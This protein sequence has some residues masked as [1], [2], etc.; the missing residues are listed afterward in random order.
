MFYFDPLWLLFSLPALA[1]MLWAQAKT[2]GAY[3]KYSEL[4]NMVGMP[5]WQVARRILDANGLTDVQIEEVPGELTDHYDPTSRV[6]RLSAGVAR[7]P[8]I[9]AMGVAAH[10]TGHAIQ[11]KQLYAPLIA[12]SRLVGPAN[13]GSNIGVY[14][15]MIGLMIQS[16]G[17]VWV[18]V[19][20]FSFAA[21]FALVTLPVEFDASKRA[22]AQLQGL[23]L[24]S[25]E[26]YAGARAVLNAAAWTYVAGFLSALMQLLYF[27]FRAMGMSNRERD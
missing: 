14:A 3:A 20:L 24:V 15:A 9:A 13:I 6:L 4:R 23:G 16:A 27:V 5:G 17:L 1:L 12:R 2:R 22:M 18:G 19:A 21:I 7:V 25:A 11:H 26:D 10:E 8:S